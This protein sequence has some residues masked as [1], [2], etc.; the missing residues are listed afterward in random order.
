M[1]VMLSSSS[2]SLGEKVAAS[3]S[4]HSMKLKRER[5]FSSLV[6]AYRTR[7]FE[8]LD[9]TRLLLSELAARS[10]AAA[11]FAFLLSPPPLGH[12]ALQ[13]VSFSLPFLLSFSSAVVPALCVRVCPHEFIFITSLFPSIRR[14]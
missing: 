13:F 2:S 10:T 7:L 14:C 3:S 5:L 1:C 11:V 4:F 8:G 9:F 6:A 12:R